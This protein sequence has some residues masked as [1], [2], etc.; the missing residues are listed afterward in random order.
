MDSYS[1]QLPKYFEMPVDQSMVHT[2]IRTNCPPALHDQYIDR[3]LDYAIQMQAV[4]D[5]EGKFIDIF[6]G[7]PGS[8]HDQRVISNSPIYLN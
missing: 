1:C 7:Y 6:I 4:C 8:V 3:K 5:H 2:Y